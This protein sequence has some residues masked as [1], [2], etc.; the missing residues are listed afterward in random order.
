MPGVFGIGCLA[1]GLYNVFGREGVSGFETLLALVMIALG[2]IVTGAVVIWVIFLLWLR[3]LRRNLTASMENLARN[4]EYAATQ[5]RSGGTGPG[6]APGPGDGRTY[7]PLEVQ[8]EVKDPEKEGRKG[9]GE[10]K[11]GE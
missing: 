6:G 11:I 7:E 9:L 5:G 2:T 10:G 4:M 3:R 8:A 1:L